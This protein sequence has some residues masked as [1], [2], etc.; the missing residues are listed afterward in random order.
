MRIVPEHPSKLARIGACLTVMG[1]LIWV[2]WPIDLEKFNFA[3]AALFFASFVTWVSMELAEFTSDNNARDNVLVD[4]VKKLNS[5]LKIVDRKQ[6]YVLREN[7]IQ[8]YMKDNDYDGLRDL[9]YFHQDDIFPF[10][11]EKI[12]ALYEKFCSGAETFLSDLYTLYTSDGH[13]FMTWRPTGERWVSDE[14]YEEVRS[15]IANL[16]RQASAL[17]R[18]WEELIVLAKQEF[19]G[20]SV[21]IEAYE[22]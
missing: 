18:S 13:G 1:S 16:D 22:L 14:I 12:Q 2:Q 21:G 8:T 9:I 10:H 17:S 19:K 20:A 4:D 11:N 5:L 7:A 3:A 6:R 15:K